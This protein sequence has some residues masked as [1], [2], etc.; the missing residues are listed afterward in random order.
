MAKKQKEK[1]QSLGRIL[2]NNIVLF[3]KV[4]KN[5]GGILC[6][7]VNGLSAQILKGGDGSVLVCQKIEATKGVNSKNY[8]AAFGF[9]V[10]VC[11]GIGRQSSNI[12][13]T[14]N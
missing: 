4:G 6:G 3:A 11:G 2:R 7:N 8:N 1:R 13:V 9:V 5:K 10:N 14:I 12:N